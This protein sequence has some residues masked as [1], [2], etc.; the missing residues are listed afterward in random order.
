MEEKDTIK[1]SKYNY[2]VPIPLDEI[3]IDDC[4]IAL[5]D[6]ADGSVGLKKSLRVMWM[7]GLKTHSCYHGGKTTFDIAHIVM[8]ENEDIF[9]YLSEEFLNDERVRINIIDNR[10]EIKFAGTVPEKEGA[11]LFLAREIQSGKKKGNG[12]LILEKIGKP[13]PN[14]WVRRLKSYDSNI[15]STYWGEKVLIKRK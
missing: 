6:F 15:N 4:E 5:N 2:G 8:E 13:Y 7:H 1:T 11:M 12:D 14:G 10:Q 3:S 9:S